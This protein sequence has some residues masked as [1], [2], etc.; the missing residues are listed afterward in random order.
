MLMPSI[1]GEQ[2]QLC[3]STAGDP[4]SRSL[5]S[6]ET[7]SRRERDGAPGFPAF[8]VVFPGCYVFTTHSLRCG[9]AGRSYRSH[10]TS[11]LHELMGARRT[12]RTRRVHPASSWHQS[13]TGMSQ[14]C[15]P[16]HPSN[17]A[18]SDGNCASG[19]A[20]SRLELERPLPADLCGLRSQQ[21]ACSLCCACGIHAGSWRLLDC[22]WKAAGGGTSVRYH[23]D[24]AIPTTT[25][26][27]EW[28]PRA[29][30][31]HETRTR[32]A[33]MYA[34]YVW[35]CYVA[36]LPLCPRVSARLGVPPASCSADSQE[37]SLLG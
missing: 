7:P 20:H 24:R 17:L 22:S 14:S 2:P 15:A 34:E 18:H 1:A 5:R 25:A 23:R 26:A 31:W 4:S 11:Q 19:W 30:V 21:A 6:Q 37:I 12:T 10:S 32:A 36:Q 3:R 9:C 27:P 16:K 8:P 29:S 33:G 35:P 13:R 28:P